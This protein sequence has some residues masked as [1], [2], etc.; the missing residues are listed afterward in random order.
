MVAGFLGFVLNQL[1]LNDDG[2]G[3]DMAG[4]FLDNVFSSF[5]EKWVSTSDMLDVIGLQSY[6]RGMLQLRWKGDCK[7]AFQFS[8]ICNCRL[9]MDAYVGE[10]VGYQNSGNSSTAVEKIKEIQKF[11]NVEALQLFPIDAKRLDG[12]MNEAS[13]ELIALIRKNGENW[14]AILAL[15]DIYMTQGKWQPAL[16]LMQQ[17]LEA[18]CKSCSKNLEL[19]MKWGTI[20]YFNGYIPLAN[21]VFKEYA[22]G[23]YNASEHEFYC[24][25][26]ANILYELGSKQAKSY[27][28]MHL[29]KKLQKGS[30][31]WMYRHQCYKYWV[32]FMVKDKKKKRGKQPEKDGKSQYDKAVAASK[33]LIELDE[34]FPL[35]YALWAR[36]NIEMI[37]ISDSVTE[38]VIE[39]KV[40]TA[41]ELAD[42]LMAE[43]LI[44]PQFYYETMVHCEWQC[45]KLIKMDPNIIPK[46]QGMHLMERR[47]C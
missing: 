7:K 16:L 28:K 13:N 12:N 41:E 6:L 9:D 3:F 22:I 38:D 47:L 18:E 24:G 17:V 36:S 34:D 25:I 31:V 44:L 33:R 42:K 27:D 35:G 29:Q 40:N 26:A 2:E 23:D 43:K 30:N 11:V 8:I 4:G 21:Q 32:E 45:T 20:L 1:W 37:G 39:E 5:T 15:A 19:K 14:D 10:V 46:Q